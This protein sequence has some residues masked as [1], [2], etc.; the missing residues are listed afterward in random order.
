MNSN[1]HARDSAPTRRRARTARA[2]LAVGAVLLALAAAPE[3]DA[4]PETLR[5]SCAN[6]LQGPVDLLVSPYTAGR[7]VAT[8]LESVSESRWA[9]GAYA[10]LAWPGL[11]ALDVGNGLYRG[12]AGA[13][14]L[15]P[16][17]ALFPFEADF[18]RIYDPDAQ[19]EVLWRWQNPL[20]ED[21]RWFKWVPF[22]TP[23]SMDLE[24]GQSSAWAD[25]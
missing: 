22:L 12:L 16:G 23:F 15:V 1:A 6:L 5:R 4:S 10:V 21:P 19:N 7:S 2:G 18:P 17:I 25:Y 14:E 13:V 3:S 20:A 8:N 9:Q 24:L 11:L